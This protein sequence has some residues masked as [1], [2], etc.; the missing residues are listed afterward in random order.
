VTVG[1]RGRWSVAGLAALAAGSGVAAGAG[2][3]VA[4]RAYGASPWLAAGLAGT[5]GLPLVL[6][7]TARLFAPLGNVLRALEDGVAGLRE[8]DFS[9]RLGIERNDEIGDLVRVYNALGELMGSERREIR[10]RE[11]MLASVLEATPTAVL[12]VNPVDRV[13]V[14]N[15]AARSLLA[16]GGKLEG[17]ALEEALADCPPE[18]RSELAADRV[19]DGLV[20]LPADDGHEV[21]QVSRHIFL[22]NARRHALL[23]VRRMTPELRRHEA[24]VWKRVIRVVGHEINNSLAPIRSLIASGRKLV[25]G[26]DPDR[27][28]SEILDT[29]DASAE[30]LHRFVDGYRRVARLP[31]PK[32]ERLEIGT[33]L[34]DLKRL[35]AFEI[36]HLDAPLE[37]RFDPSQ[38]QQVVLNLV[39]NAREAGSDSVEVSASTDGAELVLE[40]RD[41]GPGMD[42][43]A[44]AQALVPFWTTKPDGSGLGLALCREIL[45]SH[46]GSLN[47]RS[48]EGGGLVVACR[49]P[50]QT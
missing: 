31:A 28:L 38:I 46:N 9:L 44:L 25:D 2:I 43:E 26:G 27:R 12:L 5:I 47:L 32:P 13:L 16:G 14:A 30:R 8:G 40:V 15:R 45:E 41:R 7:F 39:R 10:Q 36:A 37:V 22:L 3:V 11:L 49:L 1:R 18:L 34:E 50:L 20:T 19:G 21:L 35:D 48:R 29:I 17:R 33:F 42:N 23:L 4:A 24:A 6:L